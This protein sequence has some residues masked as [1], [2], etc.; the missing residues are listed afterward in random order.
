MKAIVILFCAGIFTASAAFAQFCDP[1]GEVVGTT[2]YPVQ[3]SGSASNR[4]ALDVLDGIHI[5]WMSGSSSSDRN[6]KYNF[7]DET[8]QWLS[9]DGI[10]VSEYN[11]AGY[12]SIALGADNAA[13]ITYHNIS[14]NYVNLAIDAFRGMGIFTFYDPPD[15]VPGG[16]RAFWPQIAISANG[17][18]HLL[19]V[20]HTQDPGIYPSMIYSRSTDGGTSWTAP[21]I[22]ASVAL[23]N[24]C[25]TASPDGKVGI[26]YLNPD[27][28]GEYSQVKNDICYF[29]SGDGR[30]WD[31][32]QP[33][34]VTDYANDDLQIFC[35]WGIDA[36]FDNDGDLQITWVTGHID[37][38]GYFIDEVTQLWFYS[39]QTGYITQIAES[40][41]PV[42][43]CTYG[44]V[45]LPISMPTI[46]YFDFDT[47]NEIGIAYIGYDETDA[48]GAGECVGDIYMTFGIDNGNYWFGPTN[49]TETH[50]PGCTAG[51]CQ[52]ENFTATSEKMDFEDHLTYVMQKL[53]DI[54]D[55][56]YYLPVEIPLPDGVS[57]D[58]RRPG[59]FSLNGNY[60]NPFNARTTIEFELAK[61]SNVRLAVYD[62]TGALVEVLQDG[63][64]EAGKQSVV[65]DASKVSSGAY[66]YRLAS[67]DGFRIAKMLLLK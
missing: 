55:T 44:A 36:V 49:I 60:P 32:S 25:I 67:S 45:T 58:N 17:D 10:Q 51:N 57:D 22:V 43:D 53:G 40:S 62:I 37:N 52:S 56:I 47:F 61:G 63:Y 4:I 35:P 11:G 14:R 18:I 54:P 2:Q 27:M 29:K 59:L 16:N 39:E 20:E 3:S 28:S 15:Q 66:F 33:Q 13:A 21:E 34:C 64:M 26:V 5:T 65:W 48:S 12:P 38:D 30:S 9:Y 31:F 6:I 50:T 41:D 46:S 8:G 19:M 24:G 1:P 7:R 23:L 42:L